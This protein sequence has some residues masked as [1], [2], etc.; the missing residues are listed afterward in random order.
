MPKLDLVD[1]DIAFK[2]CCFGFCAE[3]RQMFEQGSA[4]YRL[5]L[6]SYVV[7][8]KIARSSRV[9]DKASAQ[10]HLG[11]FL[12]WAVGLEPTDEEIGLAAEIE[13]TGQQQNVDFD[14]GESLLL[15]ALLMRGARRLFTGDKRAITGFRAVSEAL[16]REKET[17]GKVVCFEQVMNELLKTLGAKTLTERVCREPDVDKTAAVCCGCASG[18]S[19]EASISEGLQ[20]YIRYLRKACGNTLTA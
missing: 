6:A 5:G 9:R 14:S 18:G 1:N 7:P 17:A 20:S 16:G 2:I 15:A 12:A 8:R 4:P 19:D 10:E 11:V 3:F 13:A